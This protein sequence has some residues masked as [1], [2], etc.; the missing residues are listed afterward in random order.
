MNFDSTGIIIQAHKHSRSR[1]NL[2]CRTRSIAVD[3][4]CENPA[5]KSKSWENYRELSY[6]HYVYIKLLTLL[7]AWVI[8]E[9]VINQLS[10]KI[11][12][13]KGSFEGRVEYRGLKEGVLQNR[14]IS[15]YEKHITLL[16]QRRIGMH[17]R[18]AGVTGRKKTRAMNNK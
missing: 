5:C 13:R 16:I 9:R 12:N 7:V 17:S 2:C 10:R 11:D 8:Y 3:L 6:L 18:R 14:L 1:T 4:R 15:V